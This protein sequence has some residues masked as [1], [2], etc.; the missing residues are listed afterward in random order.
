M[1]KK[2]PKTHPKYP[3]PITYSKNHPLFKESSLIQR[4]IPYPKPHHLF[5][6]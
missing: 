1:N 2:Y 6:D 3:K 4:I 5:K